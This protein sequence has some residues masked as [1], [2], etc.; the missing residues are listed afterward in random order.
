MKSQGNTVRAAIIYIV[1]SA[2][3]VRFNDAGANYPSRQ[4]NARDCVG[5]I[6]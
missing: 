6:L 4:L 1:L 2:L 3:P 5:Q